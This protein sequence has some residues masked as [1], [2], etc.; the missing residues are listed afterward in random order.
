MSPAVPPRHPME[1]G[2]A[3]RLS[4]RLARF[5]VPLPFDGEGEGGEVPA[6]DGEGS[7]NWDTCS[8]LH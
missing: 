4:A 7:R 3:V 1:Q 6:P 2:K 8:V 5:L